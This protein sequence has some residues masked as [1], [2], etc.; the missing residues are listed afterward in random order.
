M[1]DSNKR[2][3][4]SDAGAFISLDEMNILTKNHDDDHAAA[5]AHQKTLNPH[6]KAICF[7]RD[8][9]LELLD[10]PGATALRIY[11]GLK[12]DTD[13]DGIKEK[14]MVLVAVDE[15]GNDILPL[16]EDP[17]AL[18]SGIQSKSMQAKILDAGLPCPSYCNGKQP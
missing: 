11:F 7:G 15:K 6:I 5:S 1:S 2:P 4:P 3:I 8:K 14:K 16:P 12:I 17:A 13:G 10:Q 18:S 9:V